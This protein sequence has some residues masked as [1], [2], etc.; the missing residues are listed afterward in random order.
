[1]LQAEKDYKGDISVP[2][3]P[4]ERRLILRDPPE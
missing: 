3:D 1:M 4:V 2:D